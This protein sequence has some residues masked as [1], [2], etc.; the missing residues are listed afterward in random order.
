MYAHGEGVPK[1]IVQA[2]VRSNLA[3]AQDDEI[4]KKNLLIYEQEMTAEQKSEA[5]KIA[6]EMYEKMGPKK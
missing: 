6:R 3:G 2:H 1:D 5:M 4:A